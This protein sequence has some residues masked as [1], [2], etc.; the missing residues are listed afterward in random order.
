V[1]SVVLAG[2]VLLAVAGWVA[3]WWTEPGSL[4]GTGR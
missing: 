2:V 3:L 1:L 4:P